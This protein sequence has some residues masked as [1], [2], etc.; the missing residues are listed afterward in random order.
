MRCVARR[1][2]ERERRQED[3]RKRLHG[4]EAKER[5][6]DEEA[7]QHKQSKIAMISL[8]SLEPMRHMTQRRDLQL[9]QQ[10]V[11]RQASERRISFCDEKHLSIS[12]FGKSVAVCLRVT[13]GTREE[14]RSHEESDERGKW[15]SR[16]EGNRCK[17]VSDRMVL[18]PA[19]PPDTRRLLM[20]VCG[21][22]IEQE[23]VLITL[24]LSL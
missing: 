20:R 10:S 9:H 13:G 21:S 18:G 14:E 1:G 24:S 16:R 2:E 6:G 22:R 4:K 23:T 19:S 8:S 15:I 3:V 7:S 11:S 17:R 5:R 12:C